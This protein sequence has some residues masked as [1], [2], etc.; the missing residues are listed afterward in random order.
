MKRKEEEDKGRTPQPKSKS[1]KHWAQGGHRGRVRVSTPRP[2]QTLEQ[3]HTS[4]I[5][6]KTKA[7]AAQDEEEEEEEEEEED[8]DE[9]E[10]EEEKE[11][12]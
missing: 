1:N 5:F 7:E 11:D 3:P 8:D 10:E 12:D 9:E 2:A 4:Q 6:A